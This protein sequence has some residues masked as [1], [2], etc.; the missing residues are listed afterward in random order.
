MNRQSGKR[1]RLY[2]AVLVLVLAIAG[3]GVLIY[4]S[5]LVF[6]L[7][8]AQTFHSPVFGPDGKTVFYIERNSR[9]FSWGPG[10]E[11]FTPPA[12]VIIARDEFA[13]KQVD[14][15]SGIKST[16][17]VF[18]VPHK[19]VRKEYRNRLFGIP[20]TELRWEE[21]KLTYK[22][23]LDVLPDG[24]NTQRKEWSRGFWDPDA[25]VTENSTWAKAHDTANPWHDGTLKGDLEV[26][27]YKEIAII[28]K[29]KGK[30]DHRIFLLS[31]T[32][33]LSREEILAADLKWHSHRERIERIDKLMDTRAQLMANYISSGLSEGDASLRTSEDLER[34]GLIPKGP[35]ITAEKVTIMSED[36]PEFAISDEEFRFG[37]FQDIEEAIKSPGAEINFRGNYIRHRD[38][39]TSRKINSW[40]QKGNM[41]F[42]V[43]TSSGFYL[44]TIIPGEKRI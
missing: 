21:N 42:Y 44:M 36:L 17:H 14:I 30:K 43:R 29:G 13:I 4:K 33:R 19:G 7:D 22:I 41:S 38:F 15:E 32:S 16:V 40:I 34:M 1:R 28:L 8:R 31:D 5:R 12:S 25:T 35:K 10:M 9:G 2:I 39:N 18:N 27:N 20:S 3:T 26:I 11:F 24:P 37:L 6:S 23:G